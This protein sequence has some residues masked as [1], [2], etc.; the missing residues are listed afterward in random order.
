MAL[1]NYTTSIA[2][3]KTV[4]EMQAMLAKAKASAVLSEYSNGIISALSFQVQSPSG[5]LSFRL[6]CDVQKVY[7]V[8]V[9]DRKLPARLRTK[10]Q[11]ARIS[12]R[13]LKDWL[14]AQLA[15]INVGMVDMQQ[16]FLPYMQTANG[17]TIYERLADQNFQLA[18][19][20]R[21]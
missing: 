11:A 1:L 9:R 7:Q 10:E 19:S 13:I 21:A 4:G 2:A 8:I 5:V 14:E 17:K 15:L 6:P 12:W 20:D 3:E 16:V 18:L